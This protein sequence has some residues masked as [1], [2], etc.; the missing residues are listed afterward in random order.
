MGILSTLAC[1]HTAPALRAG[2]ILGTH[3][4]HIWL[5]HPFSG[6]QIQ[7]GHRQQVLQGVSLG[8]NRVEVTGGN[9]NCKLCFATRDSSLRKLWSVKIPSVYRT[10][11]I[12]NVFRNRNRKREC[13]R[14]QFSSPWQ[15]G[16]G[17]FYLFHNQNI[18]YTYAAI[19]V[20]IT[21]TNR[22][23]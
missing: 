2:S 14:V 21:T 15:N 3:Q 23:E 13:K 6:S 8:F 10:I 22:R 7:C 4:M 5:C 1:L 16:N 12:L 11:I 20:N 18:F 19:F 9:G 17:K